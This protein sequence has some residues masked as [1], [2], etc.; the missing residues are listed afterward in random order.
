MATHDYFGHLRTDVLAMVPADACDILSLGCGGGRTEAELVRE[1]KKVVGIE[2]FELAAKAA[3]A[4]GLEVINGDATKTLDALA[5]R[6]F[7]C[8]IYADVLEHIVDPEAILHAHLKHLRPGGTIIIS[9]PNFRH[10]SVFQALFLK[11]FPPYTDAGIFDRTHVRLTTRRLVEQ[12][13]TVKNCV[14]D[15]VNY[16]I[17]GRRYKLLSYASVGFL[18][19]FL[20]SQI[21]VRARYIG[22][23]SEP[24]GM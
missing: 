9:V 17:G 6:I 20:A 12:W 7:D 15:E 24:A 3:A 10:F 13:L 14:P 2:P 19:E 16:R 8:L 1:G 4:R 21:I 11:G 18:R 23:S 5:G 22:R